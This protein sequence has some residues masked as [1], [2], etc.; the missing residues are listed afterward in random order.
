MSI[1]LEIT[2]SLQGFT[3]AMSDY[4]EAFPSTV[5]G[6]LKVVAERVLE[7]ANVLVPVRTGFLKSTL[8]Y[9]QDTPLQ[10][11]FYATAPYA[12]YVEFG[13]R[14]MAA[15]LFLTGAF[16]S[17]KQSSRRK[18]RTY[19]SSCETNSLFHDYRR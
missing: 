12:S 14:R 16:S 10:I 2:G 15:R 18:L 17:T 19:C 13:T 7:T 4:V 5:G 11:T 6:A 3:S 1:T 8:G 9:R